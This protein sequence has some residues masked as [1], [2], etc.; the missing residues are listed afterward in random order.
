MQIEQGKAEPH[1]A[2]CSHPHS[3]WGG[4]W[5]SKGE[6]THALSKDSLVGK[7]ETVRVGKAK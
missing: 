6:K 2:A 7:A 5:K 1:A 3:G 4:Y